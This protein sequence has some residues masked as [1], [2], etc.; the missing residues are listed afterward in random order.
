LCAIGLLATRALP[1]EAHTDERK[2]ARPHATPLFQATQ[3]RGMFSVLVMF[4]G[5]GAAWTYVERFEAQAN[6]S[7]LMIGVSLAVAAVFGALGGL[8]ADRLPSGENIRA[9]VVFGTLLGVA[10]ILTPALAKAPWAIFVAAA[11][12][13][14]AWSFNVPFFYVAIVRRSGSASVATASSM[15]V[16]GVAA[17]PALAAALLASSNLAWVAYTAAVTCA[18]S[19]VLAWPLLNARAARATVVGGE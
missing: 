15:Q 3:L 6:V 11:A 16:A 10:G 14:F 12:M 2:R 9:P 19:A 18:L 1:S 17:G 13:Q 5:F 7:G 8:V 4:A